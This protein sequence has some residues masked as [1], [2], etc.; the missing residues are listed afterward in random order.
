MLGLG[1]EYCVR[2]NWAATLVL[3]VEA[4]KLL[5]RTASGESA[6]STSLI[7]T[8]DLSCPPLMVRSRPP[9]EPF[10]AGL[11]DDPWARTSALSLPSILAA[12]LK[13]TPREAASRPTSSMLTFEV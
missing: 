2:A 4:V 12:G 11:F 8:G 7:F 10:R 3:P 6:S 5:E 13:A 1:D 9:S